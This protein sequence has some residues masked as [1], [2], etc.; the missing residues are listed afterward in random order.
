MATYQI[1][2]LEIYHQIKSDM[3][4]TVSGQDI[5][6]QAVMSGTGELLM[7]TTDVLEVGIDLTGGTLVSAKLLNYPVE[8]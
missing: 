1:R 2:M 3:A 6:K 5:K 7:V 4:K 8:A